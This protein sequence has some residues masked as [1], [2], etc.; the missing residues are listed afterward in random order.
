MQVFAHYDLLDQHNNKVAEGHKASFCLED[1]QCEPGSKKKYRCE[2]YSDQGNGI[3]LMVYLAWWPSCFGRGAL[4]NVDA[5]GYGMSVVRG[6]TGHKKEGFH[7][8]YP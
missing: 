7:P 1:V 5:P 6:P 4:N 2:G 3:K 8:W